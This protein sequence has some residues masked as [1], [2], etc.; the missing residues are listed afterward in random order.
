MH[1]LPHRICRARAKENPIRSKHLF[2][3]CLKLVL[4]KLIE[5]NSSQDISPPSS[6]VVLKV[7]LSRNINFK[8]AASD[9]EDSSSS[10]SS[11]PR[12]SRSLNRV[13]KDELAPSPCAICKSATKLVCRTCK[14]ATYC[15]TQCQAKDEALHNLLCR[16]LVVFMAANPRPVETSDTQHKLGLLFPGTKP[17]PKLI[18]VKTMTNRDVDDDEAMPY[19]VSRYFKGRPS[20]NYDGN[21]DDFGSDQTIDI[22]T[23]GYYW[24]DGRLNECLLNLM[25]GCDAPSIGVKNAIVLSRLNPS[26]DVERYQDITLNDLRGA[27]NYFCQRAQTV[28]TKDPNPYIILEGPQWFRAV[29]ISCVADEVHH[30]KFRRVTV[31]MTYRHEYGEEVDVCCISD[32]L[33]IPLIVRR[34][35]FYTSNS[36][37]KMY[38]QGALYLLHGADPS[39]NECWNSPQLQLLH[40]SIDSQTHPGTVV[41]MRKDGRDLTE[42][43][44]E[45][46]VAYIQDVLTVVMRDD[47][48]ENFDEDAK[49][50]IVKKYMGPESFLK[51]FEE[52]KMKK[53]AAGKISW[54]HA[55]PPTDLRKVKQKP[56]QGEPLVRSEHKLV[57]NKLKEEKR[58]VKRQKVEKSTAWYD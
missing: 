47:D 33:G 52:Y 55:R 35:K 30:E 27:L 5:S 9:S 45:A 16:E 58:A 12:H 57:A 54:T 25:R 41:V 51:Y 23:P 38:N 28:E 1:E 17:W 10:I 56:K 13:T 29:K 22:L 50:A 14:S 24:S 37:D 21:D 18:W 11:S 19:D 34:E 6:E 4:E 36:D 26:E 15:S 53:V 42:K 49:R 31:S 40:A 3:C 39:K 48:N 46:L 44:V 7:F 2:C 8:M 43:H 20:V 32:Q